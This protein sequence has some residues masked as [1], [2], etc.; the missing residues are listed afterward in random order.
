MSNVE[1]NCLAMVFSSSEVAS[2]VEMP[3]TNA[4]QIG[5][6]QVLIRGIS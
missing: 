6:V 2:F 1:G 3:V 4:L 5:L